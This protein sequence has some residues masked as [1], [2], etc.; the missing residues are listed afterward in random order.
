MLLSA[1][2]C[3]CNSCLVFFSSYFIFITSFALVLIALAFAGMHHFHFPTILVTDFVDLERND[4]TGSIPSEL[5]GLTSVSKCTFCQIACSY[6]CCVKLSCSCPH[7]FHFHFSFTSFCL[8]LS[9]HF[10][11]VY[12]DTMVAW[13]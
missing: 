2:L 13:Q 10:Q 12:S 4:L 9:P 6:S 8:D 5:G 11:M 7:P 3:L 1:C